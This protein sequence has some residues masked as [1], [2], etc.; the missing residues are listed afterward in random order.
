MVEQEHAL[1]AIVGPILGAQLQVH[2]ADL[3][4]AFEYLAQFST[5]RA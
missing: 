4:P 5:Q 2:A 1:S 3:G